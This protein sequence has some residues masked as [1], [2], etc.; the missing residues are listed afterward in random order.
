ME[1][2]NNVK[3][4]IVDAV[5]RKL[6]ETRERADRIAE[7]AREAG[8]KAREK[9]EAHIRE[10]LKR[11]GYRLMPETPT[12]QIFVLLDDEKAAA[13]SEQ[14]VLSFWE[15]ADGHSAV[16]R[17]ATSWATADKDADRLIGLL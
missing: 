17:I 11:K 6:A 2:T 9:A 3:E 13:L 5:D 8:R 15:R 1:I 10:A 16:W 4:I 7:E 14:V 12:N